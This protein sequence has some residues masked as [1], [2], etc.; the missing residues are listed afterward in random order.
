MSPFGFPATLQGTY[1]LGSAPNGTPCDRYR[2]KSGF[3]TLPSAGMGRKAFSANPTQSWG[4]WY[5]DMLHMGFPLPAGNGRPILN[6]ILGTMGLTC[7]GAYFD[8]LPIFQLK[9]VCH[10][11]H[12]LWLGSQRVASGDQWLMRICFRSES[13]VPHLP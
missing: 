11:L 3:E 5:L 1:S 7:A 8:P 10:R 9:K 13:A 2:L 4:R 6:V 12:C